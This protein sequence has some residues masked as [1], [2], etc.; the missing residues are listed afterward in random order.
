MGTASVPV[1]Y[2][3][4]YR[5]RVLLY[6]ILH[7]IITTC[8]TSCS[9]PLYNFLECKLEYNVIGIKGGKRLRRHYEYF[10]NGTL[11][12]GSLDGHNGIHV[13]TKKIS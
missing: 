4:S 6:P 5:I 10:N 13:Q 12:Y 2:S 9:I 3:F 1:Q 7:R 8:S 11:S